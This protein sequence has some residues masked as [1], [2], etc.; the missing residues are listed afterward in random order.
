MH[1]SLTAML[2]MCVVADATSELPSF[3]RDPVDEP[4][5][6][7]ARCPCINATALLQRT[8]PE[9]YAINASDLPCTG[10]SSSVSGDCLP[11]D[12]GSTCQKWDARTFPCTG[13]DPQPGWCRS[14]WCY[15]DSTDC[16]GTLAVQSQYV[17]RG[18]RVPASAGLS[19]SYGTCGFVD[20]YSVRKAS[21]ALSNRTIRVTAPGIDSPTPHFWRED[22]D[23][24]IAAHG[25]VWKGPMA[26]FLDFLS[27][28]YDIN[29]VVQPLSRSS[30]ENNGYEN[31]WW[32]CVFE[33]AIGATDMC[34]GDFWLTEARQSM[35]APYATFSNLISST[36]Y[37]LVA[38]TEVRGKRTSFADTIAVPLRPFTPNLW[39]CLIGA[40]LIHGIAYWV[41]EN[42]TAAARR[43]TK[44]QMDR[45]AAQP[46]SPTMLPPPVE[47]VE[48]EVDDD[49]EASLRRLERVRTVARLAHG[50]GVA[51]ETDPAASTLLNSW[52]NS[53][54]TL[55]STPPFQPRSWAS[56]VV[57]MGYK[58]LVLA[59]VVMWSAGLTSQQVS[60]S[61]VASG[62]VESLADAVRLQGKICA[63]GNIGIQLANG[64]IRPYGQRGADWDPSQACPPTC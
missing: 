27:T 35:L 23:G 22:G 19:Y 42:A 57:H 34:I 10:W 48:V 12:L 39:A 40:I 52:F 55:K 58:M 7:S 36:Q 63:S 18:R 33:V 15:V 32:A 49:R 43:Q 64:D 13:V 53:V 26:A 28:S 6:P 25:N 38:K 54:S 20:D 59:L 37:L 9:I 2:L 8:A 4:T 3:S 62:V 17:F 14:E 24:N 5:F 44:A 46:S 31:E 1:D 29:F 61:L 11:Y 47:A 56:R 30:I 45:K 16:V 21:A 51:G 41:A 60:K 50:E